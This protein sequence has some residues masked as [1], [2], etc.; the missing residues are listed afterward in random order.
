M[1]VPNGKDGVEVQ[2]T[3]LSDLKRFSTWSVR[4]VQ[5]YCTYLA[6]HPEE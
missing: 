5:H 2:N 6:I 1:D 3:V 4:R